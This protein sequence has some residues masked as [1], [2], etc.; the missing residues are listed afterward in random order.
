MKVKCYKGLKGYDTETIEIEKSAILK[1]IRNL[2]IR[3]EFIE[4]D[5][6]KKDN[7]LFYYQTYTET[8]YLYDMYHL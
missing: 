8:S 7:L 6:R 5:N 1:N 3:K 4:L 2:F